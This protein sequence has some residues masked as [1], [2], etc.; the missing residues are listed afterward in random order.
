MG[1]AILKLALV[2]FP[3]VVHDWVVRVSY[4]AVSPWRHRGVEAEPG[5]RIEGLVL[6]TR[7][8][9]QVAWFIRTRRVGVFLVSWGL[10][11]GTV[12]ISAFHRSAFQRL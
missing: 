8:V 12:L 7:E 1:F 2:Q 4:K 3:L 6:E 10:G 5:I 11:C 9:G